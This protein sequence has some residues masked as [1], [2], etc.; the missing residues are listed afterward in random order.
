VADINNS[1]LIARYRHSYQVA[2]TTNAFAVRLRILAWIG[3]ALLILGVLAA[4][5]RSVAGDR[6]VE[7]VVLA[8]LGIYLAVGGYVLSILAAALAH[9]TRA[10]TDAAVHTS[11]FLS[12]DDRAQL[13]TSLL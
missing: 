6:L 8:P 1:A 4:L 3:V 7:G 2:D 11:P 12:D 9:I 5:A 10:A 13:V